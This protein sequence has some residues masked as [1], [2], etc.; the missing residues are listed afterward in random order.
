MRRNYDALTLA[1]HFEDGLSALAFAVIFLALADLRHAAKRADAERFLAS[2][3][4]ETLAKGLELTPDHWRN[5]A[6]R[7]T[8]E[9]K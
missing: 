3:W 2:Q 6:S 9:R 4:F 7:V 1:H 5:M 8:T